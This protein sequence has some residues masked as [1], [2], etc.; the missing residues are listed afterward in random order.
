[1]SKLVFIFLVAL[2]SVLVV[3]CD[4]QN[5]AAKPNSAPTEQDTAAV[6]P[7]KVT[8]TIQQTRAALDTAV[9]DGY[10]WLGTG[11]LLDQAKQLSEQGDNA[12]AQQLAMKASQEIELA[13]QQSM[14]QK[15]AGP[16]LFN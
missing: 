4:S 14:E 6:D 12:K 8:E 9:K 1:M 16:W 5:P 2:L 11:K 10:A 13:Q 7:T 3:A 15:Q